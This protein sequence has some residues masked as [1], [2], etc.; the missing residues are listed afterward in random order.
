[1]E[2]TTNK[3]KVI[4]TVIVIVVILVLAGV[5]VW[6]ARNR[7]SNNEG[8]PTSVEWKT[9]T[10]DKFNFTLQYPDTWQVSEDASI[11]G[12][13]V[14]KKEDTKPANLTHHSNF[15]HVSVYPKGIGTE[16]VQSVYVP[17]TISFKQAVTTALDYKLQDDKIWATYAGFK[18]V[19]L[20][21]ESW[22]YVFAGLNVQDQKVS[23]VRNGKVIS[24]GVCEIGIETEGSQTIV[25]GTLNDEDRKIQ[26]QILASFQFTTTGITNPPN[27]NPENL[28]D[29]M[30]EGFHRAWLSIRDS[31]ISSMITALVLF[32]LGTS[33]VKGFAL[34][35]GLGVLISMFTAITVSRTFLFALAPKQLH[36]GRLTKLLFGSGIK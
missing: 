11:P 4:I 14:Y 23:C 3:S 10:N 20:S 30:H 28:H 32:W 19:P 34:T 24:K 8:T 35:F 12:I 1:M 33:A 17:S 7:G 26:E 29:A 9:Y 2:N 16:G 27:N 13:H 6:A 31:N 25:S 22:G 21:W 15:T 36:E 18:N 5:I